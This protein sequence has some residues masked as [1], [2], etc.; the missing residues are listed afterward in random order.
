M[1]RSIL[2]ASERSIVDAT[3]L[4]DDSSEVEHFALTEDRQNRAVVIDVGDEQAERIAS[5]VEN[6]DTHKADGSRPLSAA[7]IN[8]IRT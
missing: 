2:G 7:C 6:G 8:R 5:Q 1:A 3:V 4:S